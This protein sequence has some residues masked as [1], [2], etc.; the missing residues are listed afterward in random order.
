DGQRPAPFASARPRSR[1]SF[2]SQPSKSGTAL[3]PTLVRQAKYAPAAASCFD[4]HACES[5]PGPAVAAGAPVQVGAGPPA[6]VVATSSVRSRTKA[7][8]VAWS[9]GGQPFRSG[10]AQ[11]TENLVSHP[12]ASSVAPPVLAAFAFALSRQ[13]QYRATH[14]RPVDS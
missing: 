13:A 3:A 10:R 11:S 12:P 5:P 2:A 1:E 14:S 4:S 9:P 7:W 8:I 6:S